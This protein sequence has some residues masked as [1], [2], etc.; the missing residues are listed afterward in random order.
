M[1]MAFHFKHL[2]LRTQANL[3]SDRE[4]DDIQGA[5]TG[6]KLVERKN[7]VTASESACSELSGDV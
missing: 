1:Y 4:G 7:L 3:L 2:T 6:I 5:K